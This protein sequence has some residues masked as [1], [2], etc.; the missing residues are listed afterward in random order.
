MIA[1]TLSRR[2]R[3]FTSNA[4]S[5]G[6]RARSSRFCRCGRYASTQRH[7]PPDTGTLRSRPVLRPSSTST[8]SSRRQSPTF[9]RSNSP[10]RKPVPYS[11]ESTATP[12]AR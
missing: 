9:S 2:P 7:I 10:R 8:P 5:S 3:R 6:R 4:S 12:C 1:S 11:S